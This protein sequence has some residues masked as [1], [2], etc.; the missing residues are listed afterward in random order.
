MTDGTT[1][2]R[3]LSSLEDHDDNGSVPEGSWR[4]N[5][6]S[7]VSGLSLAT[8]ERVSSAHLVRFSKD[9]L[10]E[11]WTTNEVCSISFDLVELIGETAVVIDDIQP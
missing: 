9:A 2:V 10:E 11:R 4:L 5:L 3:Y 1:V 6:D 8:I 7:T